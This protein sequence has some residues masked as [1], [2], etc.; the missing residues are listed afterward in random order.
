MD[1][2]NVTSFAAVELFQQWLNVEASGILGVARNIFKTPL[3]WSSPLVFKYLKPYVGIIYYKVAV[4]H[5]SFV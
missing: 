4:S 3:K 2:C 1:V 5:I